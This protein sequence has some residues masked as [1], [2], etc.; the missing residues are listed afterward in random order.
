MKRILFVDDEPKIL[1]ALQRMLRPQRN[2]WEMA[3]APGGEAA[4]AMLEAESFDVIVSDMR[5]PGV[6][7]AALLE[8]VREKYPGM[9]RVILSGYTE[10]EA[11]FRA[12]PVAHQF[13]LKPCDP[14]ALRI[15]IERATSLLQALNSKMLTG[16][17]GS[18]QDLPSVPRAFAELRDALS[19]PE[20]SLERVV[21]I[22]EQD[23]AICAKV[24]QLVNSAFFGVTR[25]VSDIRTAVSYLGISILQNLVLS[26]EAFRCFQPNKSI[27]GF[28]LEQFH[29]H[30]QLAAKIAAAAPGKSKAGGV[31][32]GAA[33]LHDIGKLVIAE[34]APQP[35]ARA[36]RG[37]QEEKRPL[38]AVEEQLIG[39]S[40]AEVGAY[41]LSLWG[42][43]YPLVEA[44]A[45]H[46][47][48]GRV[49]HDKLGVVPVVY[50]C[51]LLAHEHENR[52]PSQPGLITE[53][54]DANIV[55]EAG[56]TEQ[57]EEWRDR[58]GE[59]GQYSAVRSRGQ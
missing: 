59:I 6:D 16:L 32:V 15:A 3:F 47:H 46:H 58:L 11:S 12:V 14:D 45:H 39:V 5:M 52:S 2:E 18:L 48:P 40:H 43:P 30:S 49:P 29:E 1:E 54:I 31:A 8:T 23:V 57:I 4:L 38:Y 35:F 50:L 20:T 19:D 24:L 42:L 36:I 10:L 27:P 44:V 22:V 26:L 7:G 9:L 21:K 55:A 13:L 33:L 25:E 41:L 28:S 51:N 53:E 34:R 17:V 56:L 37:A